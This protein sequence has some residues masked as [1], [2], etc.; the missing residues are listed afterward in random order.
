MKQPAI[1]W[2]GRS[3]LERVNPIWLFIL[4]VVILAALSMA[5]LYLSG[6]RELWIGLLAGGWIAVLLGFV[7][8]LWRTEEARG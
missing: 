8:F 1:A 5:A 6:S 2:R 7:V 4:A 3:R